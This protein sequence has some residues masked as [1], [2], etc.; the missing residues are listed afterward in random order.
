MSI[1]S[2]KP[3]KDATISFKDRIDHFLDQ[4]PLKYFNEV[5]SYFENCID[6]AK[7]EY[8]K[9]AYKELIQKIKDK[10]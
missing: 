8:S 9:D 1:K 2:I 7:S 5:I 10:L 4:L 3:T 6:E